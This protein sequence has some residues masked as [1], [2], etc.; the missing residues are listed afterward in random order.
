M[1]IFPLLLKRIDWLSISS[2]FQKSPL[3]KME[4]G[5]PTK[6]PAY[7]REPVVPLA[8][9][10]KKP[11]PVKNTN[12][13]TRNPGPRDNKNKVNFNGGGAEDE[14]KREKYLTA[15]YGAHQMALIRKR[16]KVEM[17]IFDNLQ[18]LYETEVSVLSKCVCGAFNNNF[19]LMGNQKSTNFD[20]TYWC[21]EVQYIYLKFKFKI[22]NYF[23]V[24]FFQPLKTRVFWG[25]W[26]LERDAVVCSLYDLNLKCI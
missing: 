8:Q 5:Q 12:T 25:I 15:K 6:T 10:V 7:H 22:Y 3:I 14:K 18:E 2:F 24:H 23:R 26:R 21:I 16:L 1:F 4:V 17:W 19:I 13:N 9:P 11:Q 20:Q